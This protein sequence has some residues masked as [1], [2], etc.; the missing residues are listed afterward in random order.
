MSW[1]KT[2]STKIVHSLE[3]TPFSDLIAEIMPEIESHVQYLP[4]DKKP[5]VGFVSHNENDIIIDAN[6]PSINSIIDWEVGL[7]LTQEYSLVYAE[8]GLLEGP[9]SLYSGSRETIRRT[10]W[11]E[12]RKEATTSMTAKR[13]NI[14][15]YLLIEYLAE[16]SWLSQDPTG[17]QKDKKERQYRSLV[18][19]LL[20]EL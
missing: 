13:D 19:E 12:Y 5:V 18:R 9:V 16:M 14:H 4:T 17:R 1:Y 20:N 7:L 2:L 11:H 10:L 15:L 8:K 6:T 3:D